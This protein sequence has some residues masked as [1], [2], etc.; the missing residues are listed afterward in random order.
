MKK[1]RYLMGEVQKRTLKMAPEPKDRDSP[2]T[3]PENELYS[4]LIRRS[5][6]QKLTDWIYGYDFFLSYRWSDGRDYALALASD[7]NGRFDYFLDH[8]GYKPGDNWVLAGRTALRHTSCLILLCTKEALNDPKKR[9]NEDPI[10]RELATFTDSGRRKVLILLDEVAPETWKEAP[11]SRF[12]DEHDLY[13]TELSEHRDEPSPFIKSEIDRLFK[14]ER[15]ELKRIRVLRS[16]IAVLSL[17]VV[18]IGVASAIAWERNQRLNE[19]LQQEQ[20]ARDADRESRGRLLERLGREELGRDQKSEALA[21]FAAALRL[22]PQSSDL[23]QDASETLWALDPLP[24]LRCGEKVT[25]LGKAG[26]GS[27]PFVATLTNGAFSLFEPDLRGGRCLDGSLSFSEPI[28]TIRGLADGRQRVIGGFGGVFDIVASEEG[29]TIES[30]FRPEGQYLMQAALGPEGRSLFV[31]GMDASRN[32]WLVIHRGPGESSFEVPVT[33]RPTAIALSADDA[34]LAIGTENMGQS[35]LAPARV[36]LYDTASR[37]LLP[38]YIPHD[39]LVLA[40]TFTADS[41]KVISAALDGCV[42]VTSTQRFATEYGEPE[43]RFRLPAQVRSLETSKDGSALFA[44]LEDGSVRF[45]NLNSGDLLPGALHHESP[46]SAL[47]FDSEIP[48]LFTATEEGRLRRWL[49]NRGDGKDPDNLPL[50][51]ITAPGERI[52]APVDPVFALDRSGRFLAFGLLHDD[53]SVRVFD[54]FDRT[55]KE[56]EISLAARPLALGLSQDSDELRLTSVTGKDIRVWNARTGSVI[57]RYEPILGVDSL[58]PSNRDLFRQN[59]F[60][61]QFPQILTIDGSL[62]E[63]FASEARRALQDDS[64]T[65]LPDVG[66]VEDDYVRS[67]QS[68]AFHPIKPRLALALSDNTVFIFDTETGQRSADSWIV[69]DIGGRLDSWIQEITFDPS[70]RF[71]AIAGP[72]RQA[73]IYLAEISEPA[74]PVLVH[75]G[76]VISAAIGESGDRVVTVACTKG[77]EAHCRVAVW[78]RETGKRISRSE[79][80]QMAVSWRIRLNSRGEIIVVGL[81][82]VLMGETGVKTFAP[83]PASIPEIATLL[84]MLSGRRWKE[85]GELEFVFVTLEDIKKQAE[86]TGPTGELL[87]K[88]LESLR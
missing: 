10:I 4:Q 55:A 18:A 37:S 78:D 70:G 33:G 45:M 72:G 11:V 28:L 5:L 74:S 27:E 3:I 38:G 84:E 67:I 47:Y 24:P 13:L 57:E 35:D 39:N 64:T 26:M 56:L 61:G 34:W 31:R 19:A 65:E 50:E 71:L 79:P 85:S 42:Q 54:T 82:G 53:N 76:D 62:N 21:Y 12:F 83:K 41:R 87:L 68:V 88:G 25:W 20:E 81:H 15:K 75:E 32:Q 59:G 1:G 80:L 63:A 23:L 8:E 6:W 46:V 14:L 58:S 36:W 44:G 29:P 51:A 69:Q 60:Y 2:E 30:V 43:L 73:Q 66:R 49:L 17:L 9:G 16:A 77:S 48:A 86:K 22:R 52:V 40:L 7:L